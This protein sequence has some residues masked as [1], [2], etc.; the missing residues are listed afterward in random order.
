MQPILPGNTTENAADRRQR[1]RLH[2]F[3]ACA[4]PE[5]ARRR[6]GAKIQRI[7][8]ECRRRLQSRIRACY[9][10]F[11]DHCAR[12]VARRFDADFSTIGSSSSV[13]AGNSPCDQVR[14]SKPSMA[15]PG[16]RRWA[17]RGTAS[18]RPSARTHSAPAPA[19]CRQVCGRPKRSASCKAPTETKSRLHY[20]ACNRHSR[21]AVEMA[22]KIIEKLYQAAGD[23]ADGGKAAKDS[24]AAAPGGDPQ[25]GG[26]PR[27]LRLRD[28]F[29]PRLRP[30]RAPESPG[31]EPVGQRQ[32][33]C[34]ERA[35]RNVP[36]LVDSEEDAFQELIEEAAD[37]H[38]LMVQANVMKRL[39]MYDP[40]I[41]DWMM[42]VGAFNGPSQGA[43]RSRW[44]T[45]T[46]RW[47]TWWSRAG[48]PPPPAGAPGPTPPGAVARGARGRA[49]V[50]QAVPGGQPVPPMT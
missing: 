48:G 23:P 43:A 25:A 17:R 9:P 2:P 22:L 36:E 39:S 32:F 42:T 35:W 4:L 15:R 27:L 6:A 45:A 10:V 33:Y 31:V 30:G 49:Q 1:I 16:A 38:P 41:F 20:A 46:W 13:L 12:C 26:H 29:R 19:T 50:G 8:V 5:I 37:H 7:F 40:Q 44:R 18:A 24:R 34:Q 14:R 11:D 3:H 47:T 28:Q 21:S